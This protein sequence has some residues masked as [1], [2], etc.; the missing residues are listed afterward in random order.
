MGASRSCLWAMCKPSVFGKHAD[1]ALETHGSG[2]FRSHYRVCSATSLSGPLS[3][4]L[5]ARPLL[6]ARL[7]TKSFPQ[8]RIDGSHGPVIPRASLSPLLP[9]RWEV[10]AATWENARG[11]RRLGNKAR[12][13][14]IDMQHSLLEPAALRER[15]RCGVATEFSCASARAWGQCS[16]YPL[17]N[18][19]GVEQ[20]GYQSF[21]AGESIHRETNS[22]YVPAMID[23]RARRMRSR[24]K[25]RLCIDSRMEPAISFWRTRW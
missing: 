9:A 1:R 19:I 6:P 11:S 3:R 23:S 16:Q 13:P 25:Y 18:E 4:T 2:F 22:P 12:L 8:V 15:V 14:G 20:G 10:A 24:R 7:G 21:A 5:R 17:K